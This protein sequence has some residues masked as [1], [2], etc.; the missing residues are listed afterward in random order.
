MVWFPDGEPVRVD[1][2]S[3]FTAKI[4]PGDDPNM[5]ARRLTKK[6]RKAFRGDRIDGFDRP[7]DYNNPV[8]TG[9][10]GIGFNRA[11]N[12]SRERF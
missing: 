11:L 3:T 9:E 12:Y 6:I 4:K 1:D 7:I 10:T 8:P 2:V 5:I